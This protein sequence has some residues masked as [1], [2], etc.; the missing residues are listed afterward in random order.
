MGPTSVCQEACP[1]HFGIDI[2]TQGFLL[3]HDITASYIWDIFLE[4]IQSLEFVATNFLT[5][6]KGSVM[7]LLV[8]IKGDFSLSHLKIPMTFYLQKTA[9]I[10]SL[11]NYFFEFCPF[12]ESHARRS[13][14]EGYFTLSDFRDFG[15]SDACLV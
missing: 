14:N 2:N 6:V 3:G 15:A 8:R 5:G 1:R 4:T 9:R 12:H 10:A 7:R 13:S 11:D